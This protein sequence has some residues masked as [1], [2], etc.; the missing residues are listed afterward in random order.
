[1]K[2][3]QIHL[4]CQ[5]AF[6]LILALACPDIISQEVT[7][8]DYISAAGSPESDP[9]WIEP[10][11]YL[12]ESAVTERPDPNTLKTPEIPK[13]SFSVST[14][15]MLGFGGDSYRF[16]TAYVAPAVSA[17]LTPRLRVRAGGMIFLNTFG[18]PY[19][20]AGQPSGSSG[21]L[22]NNLAVFVAADYF[23]TDRLTITGTYYKMPEHILFRQTVAPEVYNRYSGRYALPSESMSLG[24]NYRIAKS[25]YFGAELRFSNDY[26]PWFSP[27]PPFPGVIQYDP[28]LW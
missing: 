24:L 18:T 16:G 27:A 12:M 10:C 4:L 23:V 11:P 15:M 20:E 28:L 21:S 8:A 3:L 19:P 6:A 9:A 7:D 26:Q 22:N 13:V 1:M 2:G 25:L 5:T 17:Y 14:G